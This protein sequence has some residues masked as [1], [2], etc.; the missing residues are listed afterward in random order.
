[1]SPRNILPRMVNIVQL[2]ICFHAPL[3]TRKWRSHLTHFLQSNQ[4]HAVNVI[5]HH[6][7]RQ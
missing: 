3:G 1:M 4:V 6:G 2:Q 5:V 7:G